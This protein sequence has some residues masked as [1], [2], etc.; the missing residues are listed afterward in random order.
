MHT[1][2]LQNVRPVHVVS[3]WLVAIAVT[4][5][6]MLV[7]TSLGMANGVADASVWSLLAVA[8]GFMVGGIFAGMRALQAPVLHGILIGLV[9]LVAWA[10]V[11]AIVWAAM[12]DSKWESLTASATTAVLFIQIAMAVIGALIGYNIALR[13]KPG[14][15]EHEPIS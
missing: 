4:S 5:L 14:L 6:L 7:L 12:P 3:G 13:G 2:H 15:T 11:N 9:S 8:V 10:I 1:E